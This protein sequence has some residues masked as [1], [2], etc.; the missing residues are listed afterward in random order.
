MSQS[1]SS[2]LPFLV[3]AVILLGGVAALWAVLITRDLHLIKQAVPLRMPLV[4]LPEQIGPYQKVNHITLRRE[5]VD[6]MGTDRYILWEFRDT[7]KAA[8]SA[9]GVIRLLV[10]YYT[11]KQ[12]ST[13]HL[14]DHCYVAAGVEPHDAKPLLVPLRSD[15]ILAQPDGSV[16]AI[17]PTGDPIRLPGVQVPLSIFQHA[18]SGGGGAKPSTIAYFYYANGQWLATSDEA[19]RAVTDPYARSAYWCRIEVLIDSAPDPAAALTPFLSAVLPRVMA[20]LPTVPLTR[21]LAQFR[22]EFRVPS[23]E[24]VPIPLPNSAAMGIALLGGI[25]VCTRFKSRRSRKNY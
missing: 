2:K 24:L 8:G 1:R 11:G 23:S 13:P 6:E 5:M 7:T 18:P 14:I 9:G 17:P 12:D 4:T 3:A 21:A 15:T 22:S 19:R 10:A 20:C 25:A 16:S